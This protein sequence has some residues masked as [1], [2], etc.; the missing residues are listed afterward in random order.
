MT[1]TPPLEYLI[2]SSQT[3]LENFDLGRMNAIANLRKELRE[4]VEE[5]I[6]AE[7][8][9]RLARWILECR[10]TQEASSDQ[11]SSELSRILPAEQNTSNFLPLS[12]EAPTR[13]NSESLATTAFPASPSHPFQHST[14]SRTALPVLRPKLSERAA[15]A[16]TFL[17]Q[18]GRLETDAI[19]KMAHEPET[20]TDPLHDLTDCVE[21]PLQRRR[22]R[23]SHEVAS[24]LPAPPECSQRVESARLPRERFVPCDATKDSSTHR[25]HST[26]SVSS[27]D[28]ARVVPLSRVKKPSPTAPLRA[29]SRYSL[30]ER[31]AV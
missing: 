14:A 8:Q 10:R 9:S 19:G 24:L 5:W 11:D 31:K 23:K 29:S 30:L 26:G 25:R 21:R 15:D 18:H 12:D 16:L 22:P 28:L 4:L 27:T 13:S 3:G 2:T 1:V 20:G 6:E 17:E 7:T